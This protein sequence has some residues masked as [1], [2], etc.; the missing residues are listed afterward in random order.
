VALGSAL[1]AGLAAGVYRDEAEAVAGLDNHER[2]VE[3]DLAHTALYNRCYR[4][5]YLHIAP[6]LARINE[7][8]TGLPLPGAA[9]Q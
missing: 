3:P 7:T 1:L 4:E 8:I 9:R 2:V 5:V 6:T